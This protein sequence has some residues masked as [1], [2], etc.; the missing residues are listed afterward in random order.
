MKK[1][2]ILVTIFFF[3]TN[4]ESQIKTINDEN[5]WLELSKKLEKNEID[6]NE[7][8]DWINSNINIKIDYSLYTNKLNEFISDLMYVQWEDSDEKNVSKFNN[9]WSNFYDLKYTNYDHE[10]QNGNCGWQ[11]QKIDSIEYI[12]SYK[13]G[14]WFK[15]YISGGCEKN[16]F[17]EKITRIIKLLKEDGY[18]IDCIF[19][20]E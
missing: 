6:R 4:C 3:I 14:D 11:S 8:F 10:F 7:Q 17:P 16:S 13:K 18:K 12:G 1:I 2:T 15:L 5:N 9:K 20:T 19:L